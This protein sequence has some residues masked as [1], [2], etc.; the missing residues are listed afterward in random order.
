MQ[1]AEAD[2]FQL[3]VYRSFSPS[4]VKSLN[5]EI[6]YNVFMKNKST[7]MSPTPESTESETL[8]LRMRLREETKASHRRLD[9]LM[10]QRPPLAS[11]ENYAWYLNGMLR[12]Y[13]ECDSS[14]QVCQRATDLPPR[15]VP[16]TTLIRSDLAA[17]Q[18]VTAF[19][20]SGMELKVHSHESFSKA[21]DWGRA[22]VLE[23]S[24]MGGKM[25]AKTASQRMGA[26]A[27][28]YYL[29]QLSS[30]ATH[31]WPLFCK[32]LNQ[33]ELDQD[34]AVE[35]ARGVFELAYDFFDDSINS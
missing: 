20:D 19:E 28:H 11:R 5:C 1:N 14:V 2:A 18:I 30:D 15:A 34:V 7:R 4:L 21:Q 27:T 17:L 33:F 26:P 24:A 13:T 29:Q 31:R 22:Y 35:A 3:V 10:E 6:R 12:L 9:N 8:N 23:G 32:A 16:L 25:M